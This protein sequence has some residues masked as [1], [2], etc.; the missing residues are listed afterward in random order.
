M[1]GLIPCE[2]TNLCDPA[3]LPSSKKINLNS[4]KKDQVKTIGLIG[5][6]SWE[7]T[8]EYYRLINQEVNRRLGGFHSAQ[9]VIYSVDFEEE[10]R[11]HHAGAWDRTARNMAEAAR[12]LQAAG[13]DMILIGTN[14]VHKVAD[15][16]AAAVDRPLIHIADVTAAI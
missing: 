1:D 9:I 2:H 4:E 14:T 13:A 6:L 10:Y 16:V 11:L 12:C 5:G 7:S 15:E 3:V 8:A